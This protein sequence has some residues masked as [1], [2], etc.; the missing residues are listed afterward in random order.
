M[1]TMRNRRSLFTIVPVLTIVGVLLSACAAPTQISPTEVSGTSAP[2][3]VPTNT[4]VLPTPVA[5][6]ARD[7][8][9]LP[10]KLQIC[11]D[12]PAPPLEFYDDRGNLLGSDIDT[13]NEIARRLDLKPEWV[14]SVFD[15]VI[16]AVNTGKCDIV[17][18]FSMIKQTRL[19]Q[20]DMIPYISGGHGFLVKKGNPAGIT[21]DPMSTCGKKMA[22]QLGTAEADT[23][24][25][26][27]DACVKAGKP[28]IEIYVATKA[29]TAL[30][31]LQSGRSDVF[32]Y[33]SAVVGYYVVQQPTEF[34][35]VASAVGGVIPVGMMISK[36]K[37]G[38]NTAVRAALKS[39]KDDGT[40]QKIL[41]KWG[42]G[43]NWVPPLDFKLGDPVP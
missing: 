7:Q 36:E 30:Q 38:L 15:T 3:A 41:E 40:Y 26:F 43:S 4:E 9:I 6:V 17:I 18:T 11:S 14:N 2:A 25:E 19:E 31:E 27:N 5:T 12:I 29:A 10:G 23:A 28:P 33:D 35:L 1:N 21:E 13:G 20:V 16:A 22:T 8:L 39:M 37:T 34:E 24:K 42:L 32:F